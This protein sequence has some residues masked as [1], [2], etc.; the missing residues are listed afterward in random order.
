MKRIYQFAFCE[1]EI[2][3]EVVFYLVKVGTSEK[4]RQAHT[5]MKKLT[6]KSN[7]FLYALHDNEMQKFIDNIAKSQFKTK[8]P[9]KFLRSKM[10]EITQLVKFIKQ[11]PYNYLNANPLKI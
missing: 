6:E 5:Y 3:P 8:T 7:C 10:V 1:R 2:T 9:W 11:Y 4:D